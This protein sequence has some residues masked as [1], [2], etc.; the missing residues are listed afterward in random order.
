MNTRRH[1]I[2]RLTV[3]LSAAALLLVT[4]WSWAAPAR[5]PQAQAEPTK[6]EIAG[7]VFSAPTGSEV[8]EQTGFPEGVR[9][10]AVTQGDEV[11]LL[12]AYSGGSAPKPEAALAKHTENIEREV[13]KDGAAI[14]V[15]KMW[16]RLL[17]R[18]RRANKVTWG[19]EERR[20]TA[21]VVAAR[22]DKL[23]VVAAWTAPEKSA[24]ETFSPGLV[25]G[26]VVAR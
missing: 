1:P 3:A 14:T 2:G 13:G 10:V 16:I 7:L 26:L 9:V 17:G 11:L 25:K 23:T 4:A 5:S 22:R 24:R 8:T 21:K 19:P 18:S 15:D 6:H 20:S 12:T